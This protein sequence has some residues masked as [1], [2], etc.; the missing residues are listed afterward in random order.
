MTSLAGR[1]NT[2]RG[3]WTNRPVAHFLTRT[4]KVT[5]R[6][7]RKKAKRRVARNPKRGRER[8][9]GVSAWSSSVTTKRMSEAG[10]TIRKRRNTRRKA[11]GTRAVNPQRSAYPRSSPSIVTVTP[12]LMIASPRP[13]ALIRRIPQMIQSTPHLWT[14]CRNHADGFTLSCYNL[15]PVF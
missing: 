6:N 10:G 9:A 2:K 11:E 5:R 12:V 1:G 14:H 3:I 15:P 8:P 13:V 4:P 7:T